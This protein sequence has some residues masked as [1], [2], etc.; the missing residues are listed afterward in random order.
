MPP[1]AQGFL[2]GRQGAGNFI[3]SIGVYDSKRV[4]KDPA[5]T[6]IQ[7]DQHAGLLPASRS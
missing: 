3:T 7:D 6:I 4:A 2:D 5:R 1:L